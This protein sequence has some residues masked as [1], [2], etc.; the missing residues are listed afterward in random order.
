MSKAVQI[1]PDQTPTEHT[2]SAE[3]IDSTT[4]PDDAELVA[5]YLDG[6]PGETP[7]ERASAALEQVRQRVEQIDRQRQRAEHL[8][9]EH[10]R[11]MQVLEGVKRR[12]S[13]DAADAVLAVMDGK[14]VADDGDSDDSQGG[15][16]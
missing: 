7:L 15:G 6:A 8:H 3:R 1:M 5:E 13:D 4:T 14:E 11:A 9:R 10:S 2:E 16:P 12:R